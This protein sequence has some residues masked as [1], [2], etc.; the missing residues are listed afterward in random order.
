MK[1]LKSKEGY[2]LIDD[3]LS[4]GRL[5]E[6][7]T[8]TCGHCHR[9]ILLNPGRVRAREVCRGC[10]NYICDECAALKAKTLE[11]R[12]MDRV[13]DQVLTAA[14]KGQSIPNILLP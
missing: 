2:L 11:C 13:I 3:R 8:A 9:V 5:N 6:F 7:P 4:G 12:T 10:N 1:S 14:E